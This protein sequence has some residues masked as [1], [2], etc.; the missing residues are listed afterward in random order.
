[1]SAGMRL[2][3]EMATATDQSPPPP[4][5]HAPRPVREPDGKGHERRKGTMKAL[6]S[7]TWDRIRCLL[8]GHDPTVNDVNGYRLCRRCGVLLRNGG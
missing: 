4:H 6:L 3:R 7:R 1:V 2:K 5:Y 8:L